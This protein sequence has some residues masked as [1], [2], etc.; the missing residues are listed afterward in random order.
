MWFLFRSI[1]SPIR[2]VVC[3]VINNLGGSYVVL[4]VNARTFEKGLKFLGATYYYGFVFMLVLLVI[5]RGFGL[6]S[7]AKKMERA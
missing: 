6:L 2:T 4:L 5:S 7:M 3:T 1:P